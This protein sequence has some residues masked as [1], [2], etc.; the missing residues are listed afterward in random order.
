MG[1]GG[2]RR[3]RVTI[4]AT[5]TPALLFVYLLIE[6]HYLIINYVFIKLIS[7]LLI[8]FKY[9]KVFKCF[10]LQTISYKVVS[11]RA[12]WMLLNATIFITAYFFPTTY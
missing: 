12:A 10:Y 11:S 1:T 7:S 8:A 2:P 3:R 5:Q 9:H 4:R 6:Y